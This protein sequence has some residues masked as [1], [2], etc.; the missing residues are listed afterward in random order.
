MLVGRCDMI[1]TFNM[2]DFPEATVARF[3]HHPVEQPGYQG[4]WSRAST[5]ASL[6][7]RT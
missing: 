1:A 3:R 6:V 5:I 4:S 2:W 7:A